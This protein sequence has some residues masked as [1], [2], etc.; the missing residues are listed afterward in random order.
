MSALGLILLALGA[1][2]L[3]SLATLR[4]ILG[5][6]LETCPNPERIDTACPKTL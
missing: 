5:F 2:P 1:R 3:S 6:L 4:I